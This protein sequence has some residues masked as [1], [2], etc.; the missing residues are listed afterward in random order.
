MAQGTIVG[1]ASTQAGARI[2]FVLET[3]AKSTTILEYYFQSYFFN[4]FWRRQEGARVSSCCDKKN[5]E[6]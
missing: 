3:L 6:K 5:A 2:S 1:T 4:S